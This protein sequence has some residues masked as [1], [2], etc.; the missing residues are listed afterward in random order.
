MDSRRSLTT[1]NR[2]CPKCDA[3]LVINAVGEP[4]YCLSGHVLPMFK[5]DL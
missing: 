1:D 4:L 5:R 2:K 3:S